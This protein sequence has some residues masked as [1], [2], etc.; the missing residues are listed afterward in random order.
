MVSSCFILIAINS[1]LLPA[2]VTFVIGGTITPSCCGC[3][4][5]DR[6]G[7]DVDALERSFSFFDM[8]KSST[9]SSSSSSPIS[10]SGG[11]GGDEESK[12]MVDC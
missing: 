3:I 8:D 10:F 11:G 4:D 9:R 7:D 6:F 5:G 2:F 12:R 1:S